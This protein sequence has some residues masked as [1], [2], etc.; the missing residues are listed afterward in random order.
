M[1]PV[2]VTPLIVFVLTLVPLAL[3]LMLIPVMALLPPAMLLK[4][5]PVMVLVGPLELEEPS[6]L[7]QPAIVVAPVTVTFE[8]LLPVW[9]MDDPNTDE[10]LAA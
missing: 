7:L 4:V 3:K 5:F 9:V 10:A 1:A 8:K 2:P 6:V